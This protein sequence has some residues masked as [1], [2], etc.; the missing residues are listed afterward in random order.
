VV[1][2]VEIVLILVVWQIAVGVLGLV[3]PIFLPPPEAI[4]TG[5]VELVASGEL[6]SN[7]AYSGF[8]LFVGFPL[9]IGVGVLVGLSLGALVPVQYLAGPI[10]WSL[11]ATPFLAYRPL[12]IVWFGFGQGPII[13]LVVVAAVFSILF[14]VAAGVR[15][16]D[17]SLIN[18]SRV[19]G[20]GVIGR[21]RHVVFPSLLPYFLTGVRQAVNL[22]FIGLLVAEMTGSPN[23][24][25]ALI[26]RKFSTF[27]TDQAFAV[28]L[29]TIVLVLFFTYLVDWIARFVVP[30]YAEQMEAR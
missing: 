15:E 14:N 4:L 30:W 27:R 25:G 28:I 8:S 9:A 26:V 19:F 3:S 13:F 7:I 11:Y 29:V 23:G 24:I 22:A 12:S 16:V 10:L 21:Y 6:W 20:S 18:A 1:V 5:M 17:P 2:L